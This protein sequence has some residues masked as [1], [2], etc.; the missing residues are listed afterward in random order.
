MS[1]RLPWRRAAALAALALALAYVLPSALPRALATPLRTAAPLSDLPN[2]PWW[3]DA[4]GQPTVCDAYNYARS[5][6]NPQHVASQSL[7]ASYR[8]VVACGP[9]P[10]WDASA[11]K[12]DPTVY[13]FPGGWGEYEWE[14]TELVFRYLYLA[15]GQKPY[16][17]NGSQVV[18]NYAIYGNGR[19]KII[20]NGTANHAP[21]PGDVISFDSPDGI[22]HTAIV[23]Q[24]SVNASGS[25]A[26]TI[27]QQNAWGPTSPT[28]TLAVNGWKVSG[29]G[30]AYPATGWL[31][32]PSAPVTPT[33]PTGPL[34]Y[35]ANWS[36]GMDGWT[37]T[38]DWHVA[39]GMLVNDGTNGADLGTTPSLTGPINLSQYPNYTLTATF[40]V[41]QQGYDPGFGWFVRYTPPDQGYIIGLNDDYNAGNPTMRDISVTRADGFYSPITN[42]P[43]VPGAGFHTYRVIVHGSSIAVSVDGATVAAINDSTYAAGASIGLWDKNVQL[44]VR[45][46]SVVAN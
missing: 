31:H 15:Y 17:A 29:V 35:V 7:G 37:G 21:A 10:L 14:C 3:K 40:A 20:Q 8:G 11:P 6:Q 43:F 16:K 39:G 23:T 4:N 27:L 36:Q 1:R 28:Q 38:P 32:D 41:I 46:L 30:K 34:P 22:G 12:D 9:R 19:L 18:A 45:A 2:P 5:P 42:V 44:Q 33:G 24:A 26:I 13:F 25:G